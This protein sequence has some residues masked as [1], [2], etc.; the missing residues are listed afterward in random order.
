MKFNLLNRMATPAPAPAPAPALGT[1]AAA[2]DA[3]TRKA[4]AYAQARTTTDWYL[5]QALEFERSKQQ[6]HIDSRELAWKISR[7]STAI[8]VG[9]LIGAICLV[10]L[11]RPNPPV[12]IRTNDTTGV[13]DVI[14]VARSG[15]VSFGEMQDRADLR[16][17]VEMRESYD[18]ETIQDMYDAVSLMSGPRERERYQALYNLPNAPQKALKDQFRIIARGGPVMFVGSTAQVFFSKKLI[19]VNP[20]V[21]PKTE[22]WVATVAYTHDNIPEKRSELEIDPTGFRVMSYTVDRDWTRSSDNGAGTPTVST[23]TAA[24]STRSDGGAQ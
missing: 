3:P 15:S 19:S 10:L 22:Y 6:E 14:D 4:Q 21:P 24:A 13:T 23:P 2:D 16:H 20:T 8:G 12:L 1:M 18:W 11:K 5:E 9:C 7:V 17:Y